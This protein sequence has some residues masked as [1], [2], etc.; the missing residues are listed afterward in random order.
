MTERRKSPFIEKNN[1]IRK[2]M[3]HPF[4]GPLPPLGDLFSHFILSI[5]K[6]ILLY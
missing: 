1:E 5:L 3:G 2:G 4:L 6:T